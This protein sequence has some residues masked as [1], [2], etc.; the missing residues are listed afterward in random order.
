MAREEPLLASVM[1]STILAHSRLED[2]L[3]FHWPASS[4]AGSSRAC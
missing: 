4:R 1:H 3:S 2:A